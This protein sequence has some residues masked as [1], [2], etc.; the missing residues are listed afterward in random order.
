MISCSKRPSLTM[1]N[2]ASCGAGVAEF[3]SVAAADDD[4][5][6][7]RRYM[8]II[9][10]VAFEGTLR[11]PTQPRITRIVRTFSCSVLRIDGAFHRMLMPSEAG[12]ER[13]ARTA[14][15]KTKEVLLIYW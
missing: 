8:K 3:G 1:S 6:A 14:A 5:V 13:S 9:G 10:E 7:E 4:G 15:K 2:D 11:A 12:I